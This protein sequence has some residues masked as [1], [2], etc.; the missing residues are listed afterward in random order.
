MF[1]LSAEDVAALDAA[2]GSD[3]TTHMSTQDQAAS[4]GAISPVAVALGGL[5]VIAIAASSGGGGKDTGQ[6]PPGTG[7]GR[8]PPP[9]TGSDS[10]EDDKDEDTGH[11][12]IGTDGPDALRGGAGDDTLT[13][14][15]GNNVI[16]GLAGNDVLSGGAGDDTLLGGIG[17]DRLNGGDGN[18]SLE[19]GDGY[20]FL[21][22]GAG[23]DWLYGGPV[24]DHTLEGGSGDDT[25]QCGSLSS[26]ELRFLESASGNDTIRNFATD[27][28]RIVLDQGAFADVAAVIAAVTVVD[29]NTLRLDLPGDGN[30]ITF[31]QTGHGFADDAAA[32]TWLTTESNHYNHY[33]DFI[34]LVDPDSVTT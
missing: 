12:L 19:G 21:R 20:N 8:V 15:A 17:D 31:I 14:D 13:G 24:G 7:G 23:N 6:P 25:L 16:H 30:S 22:G 11:I 4:A 28:D 34:M 2:T 26:N 18:D 9:G 27:E 5:A 29:A 3:L 32:R 1:G 10:G 33:N